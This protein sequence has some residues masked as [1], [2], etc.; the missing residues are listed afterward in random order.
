MAMAFSLPM[1]GPKKNM[2][3]HSLTPIPERDMG[4]VDKIII[5]GRKITISWKGMYVLKLKETR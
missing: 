5:K 4:K 1:A 2:K 3:L